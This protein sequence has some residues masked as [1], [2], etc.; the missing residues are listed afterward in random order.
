MA[1]IR[2]GG[3]WFSEPEAVRSAPVRRLLDHAGLYVILAY[4]PSWRPR[5]FRPLY[6]GESQGIRSRASASHENYRSWSAQAGLLSPIYR[7]FC[8]LPG[9][10]QGQR[11]RAESS[12][13]TQYGPP[14]NERLSVALTSLLARRRL[15]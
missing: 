3:Y 12:L 1:G 13:I 2:F 5:P 11:L 14:C 8:P 15:T 9:W 7:A 4:D 10:T 6:F